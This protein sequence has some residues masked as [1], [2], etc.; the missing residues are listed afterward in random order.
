[1]SEIEFKPKFFAEG[2]LI[3]IIAVFII[4]VIFSSTI[5]PKA[6]SLYSEF[7]SQ[8]TLIIPI[9]I[10]GAILI[11]WITVLSISFFT[12][13]NKKITIKDNLLLYLSGNDSKT[14]DLK[15]AESITERKQTSFLF[16]GKT[17]VPI[18]NYWFIFTDSNNQKQEILLSGWDTSTVKN[19]LFYIKGKFPKLKI[20]T[21]FYH[22]SPEVLSGIN[23]LLK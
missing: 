2:R 13:R 21:S 22:D 5:L 14:I 23:E 18:V 12:V 9:M 4:T 3:S 6:F 19:A 8:D 1:M 20:N 16:T 11:S 15:S 17:M 7:P 10:L